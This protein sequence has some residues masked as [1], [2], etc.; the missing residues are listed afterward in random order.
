[1]N[2]D[3]VM[4]EIERRLE[5]YDAVSDLMTYFNKYA[6]QKFSGDFVANEIFRILQQGLK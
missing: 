6:D 3:P 1:M 2:K 5:N 4:A